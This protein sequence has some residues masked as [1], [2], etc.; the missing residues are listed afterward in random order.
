M[1]PTE[2][3]I[4][5]ISQEKLNAM[6]YSSP[7]CQGGS[8]ERNLLLT[9]LKVIKSGQHACKSGKHTMYVIPKD[10]KDQAYHD[11]ALNAQPNLCG[12]SIKDFQG[13]TCGS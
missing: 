13:S 1:R 12:Y 3:D 10:K 7:N 8:S 4:G 9:S 11:Y 5:P 2:K 6:A